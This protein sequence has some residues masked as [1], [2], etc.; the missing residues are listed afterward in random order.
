MAIDP[1]TES[2]GLFSPYTYASNSP[3]INIDYLG[4]ITNPIHSP[5]SSSSSSSNSIPSGEG[6]DGQTSN[7]WVNNTRPS[8]SFNFSNNSS[9]CKQGDCFG[10]RVYIS[11]MT[12]EVGGKK[13]SDQQIKVMLDYAK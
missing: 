6:A 11:N 8:G 4:L 3:I 13:I 10:W 2:N 5:G 7:D 12:F 9:H 1:L